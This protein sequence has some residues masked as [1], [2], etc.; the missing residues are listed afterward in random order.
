M[1]L[2][3][4]IFCY[5]QKQFIDISIGVLFYTRCIVKLYAYCVLLAVL[6][7]RY[8][9]SLYYCCVYVVYVRSRFAQVQ[10]IIC[11]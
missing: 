6:G 11:G 1:L 5:I 3:L 4:A 10:L 2:I 9:F 8:S 7:Q